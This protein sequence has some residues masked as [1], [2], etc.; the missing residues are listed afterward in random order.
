MD[1]IKLCEAQ[2]AKRRSLSPAGIVSKGQDEKPNG[3]RRTENE[4]FR[5]KKA[6]KD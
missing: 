3:E 6:K 5:K 4:E 1:L 2:A